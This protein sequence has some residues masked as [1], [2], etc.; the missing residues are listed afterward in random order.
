MTAFKF[1]SFLQKKVGKTSGPIERGLMY[2]D[3][4]MNQEAN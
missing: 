3:T 4:S 1:L 2:V